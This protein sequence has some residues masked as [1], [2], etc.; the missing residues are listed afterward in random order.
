[1]KKLI[2]NL[3]WTVFY[4]AFCPIY[5]VF[6]SLKYIVLGKN[7]VG[8]FA[9]VAS[10]AVII[11]LAL[12]KPLALLIV[13]GI[14]IVFDLVA[15]IL[16]ARYAE[17]SK[18]NGPENSNAEHHSAQGYKIPFFDGMTIEE[19]KK[20]YRKL[21]KLYHPDNSN[22]DEEMSKRVS[23]AYNLFCAAYGR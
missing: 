15:A 3:L 20:E 17:A 7:I 19:A 6:E 1:M 9:I 16:M 13:L 4:I 8:K 11:A 12:F 23:A 5:L 10:Y 2:K 21:M 14:L 22:G 18:A